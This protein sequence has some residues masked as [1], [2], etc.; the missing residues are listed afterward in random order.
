MS[1]AIL[2]LHAAM[3][4]YAESNTDALCGVELTVKRGTRLAIVGA[5]GTGKS[6]LLLHL[7]GTLR[8]QRGRVYLCGQ[9]ASYTRKGLVLWRSTVGVLFQ[10]PDDQLFAATVEQDVSF[11]PLNQGLSDEEARQRASCA[12][13]TMGIS[14][15][16]KRGPH[17]L[18]FG[19]KRRVA[20]AGVLAMQP[21]V[22]VLDEPTAGLD[23]EGEQDISAALEQLSSQGKTLIVATHDLDFVLRFADEVAILIG[24]RVLV[25]GETLSV[26]GDDAIMKTAKLRMPLMLQVERCLQSV[27]VDPQETHRL[28]RELK[29]LLRAR[30]PGSRERVA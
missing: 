19:Q 27:G 15:L 8:P 29:A 3:F 25:Q 6:T 30:Y 1:D 24:G 16:A 7:N 17:T 22:V 21:E 13:G 10:D 23:H 9:P 20:L 26:L 28:H 18:S 4:R 5:N 11:G 14:H 2:E 12:L